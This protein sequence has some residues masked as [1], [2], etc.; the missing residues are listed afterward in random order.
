MSNSLLKKIANE[1]LRKKLFANCRSVS[2]FEKITTVGEGTYGN[3]PPL[4]N[5]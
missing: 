2:D 3:I 4:P 5:S 1:K